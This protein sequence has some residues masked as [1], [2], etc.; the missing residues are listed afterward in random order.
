MWL[1]D[2]LPKDIGGARMLLYGYD[3]KISDSASF[4]DLEGVAST[5]RRA[6]L[7]LMPEQ[8]QVSDNCLN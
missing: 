6:L 4:Q 3:V 8:S 1:R 5:F 7:S 2:D